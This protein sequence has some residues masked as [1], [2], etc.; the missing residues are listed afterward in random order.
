MLVV[1]QMNKNG[2][3][4]LHLGGLGGD[5]MFSENTILAVL[6]RGLHLSDGVAVFLLPPIEKRWK[7]GSK[8][9]N[10]NNHYTR[11]TAGQACEKRF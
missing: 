11:Q 8:I 7:D 3:N 1:I 10:R 6:S 9:S 2:L 4:K 5:Y